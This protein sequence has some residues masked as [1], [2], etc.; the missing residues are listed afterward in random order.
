VTVGSESQ[1]GTQQSGSQRRE[2][3]TLLPLKWRGQQILQA[4]LAGSGTDVWTAGATVGIPDKDHSPH[5]EAGG[6]EAMAK[7]MAKER[8][9]VLAEGLA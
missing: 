3:G 5:S 4:L 1:I 7:A 9:K 6:M 2:R 8:G